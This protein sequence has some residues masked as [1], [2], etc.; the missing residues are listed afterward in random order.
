MQPLVDPSP[1]YEMKVLALGLPRSGTLSIAKALTI[2]GYQNVHHTL[3]DADD[4]KAAWH[5]FNRAADATFPVLPTY[6]GQGFS[7]EQW[8]KVYGSCEAATEAAAMFG[9]HIFR[10]YP[11]AKVVL[12][13]RDFDKWFKSVDEVVITGLWSPLAQLFACAV[14]PLLGSSTVTA[15]RK[16]VLG[17]FE[18]KDI[19]EIR[20]N[21][22]AAYDRHHR[23]IEEVVPP[24][25]L[26]HYKMGDGWE[27]LCEFLG[28]PVPDMEFPWVNE[29]AELKKKNVK[30][31]L[32]ALSAAGMVLLPWGVGAG[33]I[34]VASWMMVK[35]SGILS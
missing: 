9:P 31:F 24:G 16:V 18:A 34:G 15:M 25:Q 1:R 30:I 33:A 20:K 23:E 17:F 8:D 5:V 19:E 3:T 26:L 32:S 14:Q 21:P 28:K 11:D 22:R 27:P 2:L 10:A 4:G 12:V 13:R 6:N 7:R 35:K 29:T